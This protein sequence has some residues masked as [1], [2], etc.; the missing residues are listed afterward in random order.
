MKMVKP[1][2]MSGKYHYV[3]FVIVLSI[4]LLNEGKRRP[5]YQAN[6]KSDD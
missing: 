2:E 6:I 1:Q 3:Q 4:N 5:I